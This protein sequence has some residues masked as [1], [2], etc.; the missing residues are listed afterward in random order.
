[1]SKDYGFIRVAAVSPRVH[2][3]QPS[4]NAS[5]MLAAIRKLTAEVNPSVI[6]FPELGITGYSCADLFGQEALLD[7][8]ENAVETLAEDTANEAAACQGGIDRAPLIALGAPIRYKNRLYNCAVLLKGGK[9]LGIVPKTYLPNSAE[10]YEMRWFESASLLP[11]TPVEIEFAGQKTRF[12]WRQL[13]KLGR[14]VVGVEIC[15]DLW[16]PIPPSSYEALAGANLILNL[17]AS[18]EALCKHDYRKSLVSST[19]ARLSA[20]YVY[21]SNSYGESTQ[22]LVWAGSSLIYENGTLLAENARFDHATSSIVADVDIE[23]MASIRAKNPNY[24]DFYAEKGEFETI[25]AGLPADTDFENELKR[26]IEAH[27]FVPGGDPEA[28]SARCREILAIQVQGLCM[29]LEHINCKTA[30]IGISGGLDSTLAL[31][32]TALAFDK[33]GWNRSRIV[34]VTMPGFGTTKRTKGN[35]DILMEKL[36]I[37][38]REI[39]IVAASTQHLADIGHDIDNHDTTYEN[40]QARERT[41]ILMDL[42]G[43]LGGIV[44]G[45]GDLSEL[46][47]GW[48]T[49]NGDHMSMYGVNASIPKTLVRTLVRWAA[50]QHFAEAHDVLMDIVD[51]PIS[52]ELLPPSA[53]GTI[54]QVTEDTVGPYELH[55]FFLYNVMRWG[56]HPDKVLMLAKH[57]FKDSYDE[58]TLVKWLRTFYWRFCSQQFKRSCLPDGPKVG[59]VSLS[60]RGDWRMPSDVKSALWLSELPTLKEGK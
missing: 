29:R 27:P 8:A 50:D 15:Q 23:K 1:M 21:C 37:S 18:N 44:V 54:A 56:Y 59:S 51:T 14:A 53:D 22:D 55:D 32:V 3:A 17:S 58:A 39:S 2:L 19:S 31:L 26:Y 40:A 11:E 46:A 35:A 41:Q 13:F 7:A 12:G 57:A 43:E 30:V 10:F 60:P 33:L 4:E 34:G 28:L 52:P 16:V 49:Y 45:T 9:I 24:K 36:G 38:R 25:D 47:L 5:E 20:A 6:V 42:A 48:C